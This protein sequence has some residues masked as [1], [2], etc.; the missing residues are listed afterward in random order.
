MQHQWIPASRFLQLSR[1]FAGV[2]PP[3]ATVFPA[4]RFSGCIGNWLKST[5][6]LPIA[7][8]SQPMFTKTVPKTQCCPASRC[9]PAGRPLGA[10]ALNPADFGS[11]SGISAA[12]PSIARDA[13]IRKKVTGLAANNSPFRIRAKRWRF[14]FRIQSSCPNRLAIGLGLLRRRLYSRFLR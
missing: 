1:A 12:G 4:F 2:G 14:K 5:Q 13:R 10:A 7:L 11:F 8:A 3:D 6:Y 9:Q